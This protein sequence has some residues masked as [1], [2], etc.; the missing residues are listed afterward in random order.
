MTLETGF[1]CPYTVV[2]LQSISRGST[3]VFH[4]RTQFS[5]H[6]SKHSST[7]SSMQAAVCTAASHPCANII[8]SLCVQHCRLV[9]MP[10]PKAEAEQA[11]SRHSKR[12]AIRFSSSHPDHK[13]CCHNKSGSTTSNNMRRAMWGEAR[14]NQRCVL[15]CIVMR[16]WGVNARTYW[17]CWEEVDDDQ[18]PGNFTIP[19]ME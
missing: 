14:A 19:L 9:W 16:Q 11:G 6:Q 3:R 10:T 1:L 18:P 13:H 5:Y 15:F 17:W 8:V 2:A 12:Q 4:A 7:V